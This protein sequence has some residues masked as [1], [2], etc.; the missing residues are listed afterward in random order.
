MA[1]EY[2]VLLEARSRAF[3]S[4]QSPSLARNLG[5]FPQE[6]ESSVPF[7]AKRIELPTLPVP[8]F[9]ETSG[10]GIIFVRSRVEHSRPSRNSKY[11]LKTILRLFLT[12][13]YGNSEELVNHLITKI[14]KMQL[15]SPSL[16][17]Q[18]RIFRGA[19]SYSC[20]KLK[21]KGEHVN[22]QWL[23]KQVL[24]KELAKQGGKMNI[25]GENVNLSALPKMRTFR[26]TSLKILKVSLAINALKDEG[27]CVG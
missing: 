20:L 8:T 11:R 13:K 4:C 17:V 26:S 2:L 12:P 14:D 1:H 7:R 19:P 25:N 24:S 6:S 23:I 15:R 18:A 3:L 9:R 16:K 5:A 10:N 21:E 27:K 22:S